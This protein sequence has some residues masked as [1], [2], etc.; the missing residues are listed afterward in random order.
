MQIYMGKSFKNVDF[1]SEMRGFGEIEWMDSENYSDYKSI[2]AIIV[3][4][5]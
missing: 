2:I 5:G 4:G 3:F 1:A